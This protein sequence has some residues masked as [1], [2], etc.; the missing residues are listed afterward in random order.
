MKLEKTIT[1]KIDE[2]KELLK[3]IDAQL[4]ITLDFYQTITE[5][6]KELYDANKA[7]V[8]SHMNGIASISDAIT[9]SIK[10]KAE[11]QDEINRLEESENCTH[12]SVPEEFTGNKN[13]FLAMIKNKELN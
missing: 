10:Q 3:T 13:D 12:E 7:K 2:K 8:Q 1:E 5:N 6:Y 9:K 11:I 4:A